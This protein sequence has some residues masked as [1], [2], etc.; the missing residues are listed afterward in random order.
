MTGDQCFKRQFVALCEEAIDQSAIPRGRDPAPKQSIQV[1]Q[2]QSFV[3][4]PHPSPPGTISHLQKYCPEPLVWVHR[5]G[6][7][8]SQREDFLLA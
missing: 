3:A 5:T 8:L 4:R 7:N 2:H 6:N 1:L